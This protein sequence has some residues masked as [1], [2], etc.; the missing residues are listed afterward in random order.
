MSLE[1]FEYLYNTALTESQSGRW[2]KLAERKGIRPS[3]M[4]RTAMVSLMD[5]EKAEPA[6]RAELKRLHAG[7]KVK[8]EYR[9]K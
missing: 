3:T 6:T 7:R 4:V 2:L 1:N 8:K 9:G 5:Q